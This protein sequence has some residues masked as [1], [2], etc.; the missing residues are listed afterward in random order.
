MDTPI[1]FVNIAWM[2]RYQGENPGDMLHP[3]NFGYFRSK[4]SKK[5]DG[6]EQWNFK[7][8]DGYV[9][10][11]APL[12]AEKGVNLRRLGAPAGAE[13]LSGVL[14]VFMARDSGAKQLKVVGYYE[15]ATIRNARFKVSHGGFEVEA[16]FRAPADKARIVDSP[17]S[18]R[19]PTFQQDGSGVGQS[20]LWYA[21]SH[22]EIVTEV[23]RLVAQKSKKT[24]RATEA[25]SSSGR[26]PRQPDTEKR[27]A[28]E[29][30]SMARAMSTFADAEDVSRECRGWDIE[31]R[32][33]SQDIFIEV[34]GISGSK[35][36]FELTPNEY[37][38][39]QAL[40]DR[41]ILY[42]VTGCLTTAELAHTFEHSQEGLWV[43]DTN[44]TLKIEER[45][46]ARCS[47]K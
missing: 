15:D 37:E 40:T 19:I 9:Y 24:L 13:E 20:T 2:K 11:Y 34:K 5:L 26:R 44:Y 36:V 45:V 17:R 4:G 43:S 33:G 6:H 42:V 14:V 35:P 28:I 46:G 25:S 47:T 29:K 8:L 21:D 7:P 39:M 31:A 3:G 23:R 38:K 32:R 41:Y 16:L 30:L 18:I 27:L 12:Q 1:V 22:P 10:G